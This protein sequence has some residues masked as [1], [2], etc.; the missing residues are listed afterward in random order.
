MKFHLSDFSLKIKSSKINM[1]NSG[2]QFKKI[3]EAALI[4]NAFH[5]LYNGKIYFNLYRTY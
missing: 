2:L 4:Y 3:R 1:V 5:L